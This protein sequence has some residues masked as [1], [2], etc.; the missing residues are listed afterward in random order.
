[1]STCGWFCLDIETIGGRPEAAEE[2][3]R[4]LWSPSPSW[5]SSTIGERYLTALE[6]KRERLALI[7]G[8]NIIIIGTKNSRGES[9]CLHC[10]YPHEP[11]QGHGALIESFNTQTEM[12]I[13]LRTLLES[14]CTEQTCFV[15]HNLTSFDLPMLRHAYVRHGIRLPS[16]LVGDL[17]LYDTMRSYSR[18]STSKDI[19]IGL[20]DLLTSLGLDSHKLD[21]VDGSTVGDMYAAGRFDELIQYAV[22]DVNSTAQAFLVM[23]GLAEGLR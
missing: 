2:E 13:A 3:M 1:L 19:F 7:A 11:Q 21:G 14:T 15:G 17:Q 23:T 18:F 8:A 12:L 6:R 9:R 10:M 20:H 16:A 4:R 5:K 22:R